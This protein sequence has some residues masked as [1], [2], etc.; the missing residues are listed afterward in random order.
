LLGQHNDGIEVRIAFRDEL[1]SASVIS[2][3]DTDGSFDFAIYDDQSTTEVFPHSGTYFGRKS[4]QA[5]VI[6]RCLRLYDL[7][8]HSSHTVVLD[9][10]QII[11]ASDQIKLAA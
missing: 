4:S 7:V 8:E 9:E 6:E 5:A 2:G 1:P 3:R 11:L 10:G